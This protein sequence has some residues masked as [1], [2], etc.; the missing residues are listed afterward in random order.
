M[1]RRYSYIRVRRSVMG[2]R[3]IYRIIIEP[4]DVRFH[5]EISALPGCYSWGYTDDEALANIK[6]AA[7]L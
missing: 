4:D 2:E 1:E 3:F 6:E 7:E 5:A